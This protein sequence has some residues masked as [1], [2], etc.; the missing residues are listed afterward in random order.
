MLRAIEAEEFGMKNLDL[1]RLPRHVA[2]IMDGNGRWAKKRILERVK[3]HEKGAGAVK[4][5]VTACRELGID[6]LSLY[7]FSEEN[8]ARPK[9]EVDALMR[10]L[11]RYLIEERDEILNNNIRLVCS[12]HVHELPD[13]VKEK[14]LP[15]ME[16]S[17]SNNG[18]FL[19]LCLA[20]G[21]KQ[22]LVD[23]CVQI[24]KK[25]QQGEL[26]PESITKEI[27]E[28]HLYV[29]QL[30]PVDLMI[31]TS[32]EQRTS[33]FLPWQIAYAEMLFPD[34]FW[35]E[36]NKERLYEAIYAYQNRERRF[37]HISEQLTK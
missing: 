17:S 30:P 24:A 19:N 26:Q 33:G 5:T 11:E 12:G 36:F 34:Y 15:L 25:V 29:P 32:G 10:L 14:L 31:R 8:W 18:M 1:S 13:F 23:A 37:G 2:I 28:Q 21:G 27:F 22:E 16:E 9:R 4:V 20:Y 6:A 3:G 7:A 35:P